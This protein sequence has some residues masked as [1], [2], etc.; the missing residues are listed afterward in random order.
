MRLW[1][2]IIAVLVALS[3][4]AY[5]KKSNASKG[6]MVG[7]CSG[8]LCVEQGDLG[9]T[10]CEWRAAYGCYQIHGVCTRQKNGTCGWNKT[11]KLQRCLNNSLGGTP[12]AM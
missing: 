3:M 10:T 11:K 2:L 7:G 9:V 8:Q 5:A 4:P 1:M 12:A 6:C